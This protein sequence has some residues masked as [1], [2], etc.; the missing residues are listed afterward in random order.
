MISVRHPWSMFTVDRSL[1]VSSQIMGIRTR[2][3]LARS[4]PKENRTAGQAISDPRQDETQDPESQT[5]VEGDR[6]LIM[7]NNLTGEV[8]AI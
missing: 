1:L 6:R 2:D 3:E 5:L 4:D 8:P 7:R